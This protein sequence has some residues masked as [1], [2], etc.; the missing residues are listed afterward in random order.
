[1]TRHEAKIA[2]HS[3]YLGNP[4]RHAHSGERYASDGKCTECAKLRSKLYRSR[5]PMRQRTPEKARVDNAR[6]YAA[7][8]ER[9]LLERAD[10]RYFDRAH[11]R[12][13]DANWHKRNTIQTAVKRENRRARLRGAEGSHTAAEIKSLY[14]QQGGRCRCC[15]ASLSNGYH[16]DHVVP[17]A[18]G[19][20]NWIVN[21]QLLCPPCNLSK[22]AKMPNAWRPHEPPD[23]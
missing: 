21:I 7:N 8:R 18:R 13:L 22:G 12:E 11:I 17:L 9:L 19:G 2:G 1:M 14:E 6:Y 15:D 16:S 10:R 3:T 5:Y 23:I 20:S 4:C